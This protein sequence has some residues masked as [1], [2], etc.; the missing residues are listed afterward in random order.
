MNL[1]KLQIPTATAISKPDDLPT[2]KSVQGK[3]VPETLLK[4]AKRKPPTGT[5]YGAGGANVS[6]LLAM[7]G[8]GGIDKEKQTDALLDLKARP[9]STG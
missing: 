5:L 8:N 1:Q 2:G 4:S 6:S 7:T 3:E 9:I